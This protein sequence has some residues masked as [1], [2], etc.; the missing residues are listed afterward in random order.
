LG[1][2]PGNPVNTPI[3]GAQ[4]HIHISPSGLTIQDGNQQLLTK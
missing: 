2:E 4:L 3:T 1:F